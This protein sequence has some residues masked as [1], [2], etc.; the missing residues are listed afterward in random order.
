MPI[1]VFDLGKPGNIR[2]AA[3]GESIGTLVKE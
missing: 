1:V 3:M 2:R